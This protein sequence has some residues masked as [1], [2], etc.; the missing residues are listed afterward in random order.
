MLS[1]NLKIAITATVLTL[2]VSACKKSGSKSNGTA[3]APA[4]PNTTIVV[5]GGPSTPVVTAPNAR[6]VRPNIVRA[7]RTA[8]SD[9][10]WNLAQAGVASMG[11]VCTRGVNGGEKMAASVTHYYIAP[12]TTAGD[13]R[14][15]NGFGYFGQPAMNGTCLHP[16]RSLAGDPRYYRPGEVLFFKSL[17]GL[18][19]GTGRNKMVHD[20]FMVVTDNGNPD[21]INIEGRFGF[22]WGKCNQEQNGFCL[23]DGAVAIDFALT[24]SQYCRAWRPQD[25][26]FNDE[27]KLAVYNR[28]RSE[29]VRRG[30]NHAASKFDLDALIGIGVDR[31]GLIFRRSPAQ[32]EWTPF[33]DGGN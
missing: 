22:F 1:R 11:E 18:T 30:D 17:V 23:D 8:R 4:S 14:C 15:K 12:N 19:C 24:F 25:P 27:I 13:Y 29:A 16:C 21:A 28:V 32:P 3:A 20:G 6:P 33:A 2:S 10:L 7:P 5:P 9:E 31:D 26:L